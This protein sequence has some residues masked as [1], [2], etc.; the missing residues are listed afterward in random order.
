MAVPDELDHPTLAEGETLWALL[1]RRA[2]L[3]PHH[4]MLIDE[5]DRS[6]TFAEVRDRAERVAAGLHG[7]GIGEGTPVTWQLPTRIDTVVF[8]LAL[9]RLGAVQNPI[10]HLYREREVGSLLRSTGARLSVVPGVWKGF[11]YQAMAERLLATVDEPYD[12]LVTEGGLPDGDPAR[13]PAPP[14]DGDVVRWLYTTSGTT[15]APKAVR[16]TDATLIAGGTGIAEALR[17]RTDDV[18]SIPFPFAHIG[19]PDML[20]LVLRYGTP[21]VL[22]EAFAPAES[23]EVF[24][25][26]KVTFTGGS[27]AFYLAFLNEQRKD[28]DTHILPTL[29]CLLGGGAPKPPELYWQVQ[30][31]LGVPIR[32]GYG[33]TECPMIANGAVGDTDEQLAHTEGGPVRGCEILVVDT[34]E[35]PVEPG[36]DGDIWVRGPMVAKGYT[37]AEATAAAFRDDGWFRTGDR[38]Y[39]RADGH[40]VLTGRTKELIIRK[41]ENISPR[42]VEDVLQA[43]P[44]VG[45]VAVIGLAD[46]ERG[47]RVCAVVEP[48]PGVAPLTFAAMQQHCR[49]A[50]LMTQKIP[51]QLEIVDALPRNPTLKVLK[52]ELVQRFSA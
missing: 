37:D 30:R 26:H 10:I 50:G 45:A 34:D 16:H 23:L 3:T 51:E 17:P 35:V 4:T 28:P 43:H 52:T 46:P 1:E 14:T 25:R 6:L 7:A 2:E 38:G 36:V 32:H 21:C 41:G 33:M 13:L 48:T 31:E 42:E 9:C 24:R 12:I 8:S 19:G 18:T 20:V 29:R 39:L 47:E 44:A 15:S 49:D 40:I 11:D 27:T 22:V 5:H